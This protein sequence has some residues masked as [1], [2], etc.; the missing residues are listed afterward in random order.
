MNKIRIT[1]KKDGFRR[2]KMAHS[3][4]ATDYPG[5][6]FSSDQLEALKAEPM[7]VVQEITD[8]TAEQPALVINPQP[9]TD[10]SADVNKADSDANQGDGDGNPD[11]DNQGDAD[12]KE[13]NSADGVGKKAK[14]IPAKPAKKPAA[15]KAAGAGKAK[16]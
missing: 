13:E 15:K 7:L 8:D 16:K 3:A 1:A 4:K 14:D 12:K 11:D 2:C 9:G 10:Q 6:H 5:D